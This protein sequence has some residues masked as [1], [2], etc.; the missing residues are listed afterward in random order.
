[1]KKKVFFLLCT[2]LAT[3]INRAQEVTTYAGYTMGY[4]DTAAA[5]SKFNYPYGV[6]SD[7]Q[8][9]LFVA[10]SNNHKIRKIDSSGSNVTTFAGNAQ[11]F[12]DGNGM[13]P[14]FNTPCSITIDNAGNLYVTDPGN[15]KIR[16]ITP[17]GNVST[18]AG[19]TQGYF[20]GEGIY[21][22]FNNP[23]G[24]AID[25]DGNLYVSDYFYHNIR[26]ITPLGFVSTFA[27]STQGF[28]DGVGS[29]AKFNHPTGLAADAAG[30]IYVADSYNA[31]IRKITPNGE[32]TTVAGTTLGYSDGLVS[33]AQ[34]Y[35]PQGLTIDAANNIYVSDTSNQKIRK[36]TPT[37]EVTTVAGS[38]AGFA[39][40]IGTAAKFYNPVGISLDN[41][42]NL[43]VADSGN[44]KIRK[45]TTPLTVVQNA[46]DSEINVYPN[47]VS[48][49]LTIK[50]D[51]HMAIDKV[52][53]KALS[54][55]II[56]VQTQ[57][58]ETIE[59]EPLAQGMYLLEVYSRDEKFTTKF[60]KE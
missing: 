4:N 18:L 46:S 40:A 47:P 35:Y 28:A 52:V 56:L 43:L 42:G 26:K 38:T 13:S 7:S 12:S 60:I 1:M 41:A 2:L 55:K 44:H 19:S 54:G 27:G 8:G 10:D 20:D 57:H 34:F 6:V 25:P 24:I 16:K 32:V 15:Y 14:R 33:T 49:T 37:G 58:F 17:S 59:V 9:N 21:A 5:Y 31:K 23:F 29:N 50:T 53:I 48:T 22:K 30:N 51:H 39:N 3:L 36:I 45:I 11:G